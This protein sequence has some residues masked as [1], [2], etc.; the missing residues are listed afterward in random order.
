MRRRDGVKLFTKSPPSGTSS[1]TSLTYLTSVRLSVVKHFSHE[2]CLQ[3]FFFFFAFRILATFA[4][5]TTHKLPKQ[6]VQI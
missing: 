1:T 6:C 3:D 2:K 4:I 5:N